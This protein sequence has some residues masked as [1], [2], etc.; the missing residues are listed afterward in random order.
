MCTV[1][2]IYIQLFVYVTNGKRNSRKY[3]RH[4]YL[5]KNC[6]NE[7]TQTLKSDDSA[8]DHITCTVN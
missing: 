3:F 1:V 4:K 5:R 2:T 7:S 8:H 6:S